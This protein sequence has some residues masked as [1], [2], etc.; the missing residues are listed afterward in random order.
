M[1]EPPSILGPRFRGAPAVILPA[2]CLL[3]AAC[4]PQ[5][6]ATPAPSPLSNPLEG[7]VYLAQ[8]MSAHPLY[9]A[10]QRLAAEIG[11]LGRTPAPAV[12]AEVG[13][14]WT[15][16]LFLGPPPL[17]FP[18][19]AFLRDWQT[20][21][22]G[23]VIPA[24]PETAGLPPDLEAARDWRYRQIDLEQARKLAEARATESRR[25]A[26]FRDKLVRDRLEELTN[27]GLDLKV[28]P[29]EAPQREEETRRR[30][31]DEIEAA[32]AREQ[33]ESAEKRLPA[34]Q[35]Q[36]DAETARRKAEVDAEVQAEARARRESALPTLV[37]PRQEMEQRVKRFAN[38]P[39]TGGQPTQ[40]PGMAPTATDLRAAEQA[41]DQALAEYERTRQRQLQ[42]LEESQAALIRSIL[43]DVRLAAMRAAFEDNLRLNLV[44]PGSPRGAD[45]TDQVRRRVELIWSGRDLLSAGSVEETN[46]R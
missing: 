12:T 7:H 18:Q 28:P 16:P 32:V 22:T 2:L 4:G 25:L 27:A 13:E 10:A 33:A 21:Q 37:E 39:S 24:P 41:R 40:L 31:W 42:R 5:K 43:A 45:L 9:P 29:A 3:L 15:T 23:L 44:P 46:H 8:L 11:R 36:L 30:I 26:Q 35:A 17:A 19:D 34:V 1:S 20:W 6:V 14:R 38:P